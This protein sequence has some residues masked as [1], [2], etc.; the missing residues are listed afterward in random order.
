VGL[1]A[2]SR[3]AALVLE[4]PRR[5]VLRYLPVPEIED[6]DG[7]LRVEACG[8]CG[9]DHE[10]YTGELFGGFPFIPGHESVGVIEAIGPR[11]SERWGVEEGDRVAVAPFQA[12]RTCPSC[13][14]GEYRA[15]RAHGLKDMYG[16]TDVGRTPGLWGGYAQYQY[17]APDSV[18][19]RAPEGLSPVE[20]TLFNPLGAGIRWGVTLPGTQEG[21]VVAVLGPGIRGLSVTL[22]TRR[23]G[24]GFVMVTGRG[25]RDFGRL[26]LADKLGAHAVVDVESDDPVAVLKRSVG[27][28]ADV[29]VDVTAKA[30]RALG[31]AI[32][33]A[34]PGGTIVV[35]G[36][37][38]TDETPGFVPDLIVLKELRVLGALGVDLVDYK[39]ALD[40][41]ASDDLVEMREIERRTVGLEDAEALLLAMSGESDARPVHGVIEPWR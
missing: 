1:G 23:A 33:L 31:Q 2:T 5:L 38:G 34:R 11:A 29:V 14:R 27:R 37:R 32:A 16:F 12:C 25:E 22:A 10:Q 13:E 15:C 17:L 19:L 3:A 9:T 4:A 40:F 41:L 18:V 20:T 39:T 7:L 6:D 36:T 24:A 28:L 35:A 21:D 8:L 26:A 30:P